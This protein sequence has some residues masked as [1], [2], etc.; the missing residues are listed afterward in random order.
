MQHRKVVTKNIQDDNLVKINT[1]FE[2]K[3]VYLSLDW[4]SLLSQRDK[5]II[6][7]YIKIFKKRH[8]CS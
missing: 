2:S 3:A 8:P 4:I 1:I 7:K 5:S 6:S